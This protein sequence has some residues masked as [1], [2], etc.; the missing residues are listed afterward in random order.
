MAIKFTYK[1]T[2]QGFRIDGLEEE[3]RLHNS[4]YT[5]FGSKLQITDSN[6]SISIT[7]HFVTEEENE[8]WVVFC[9]PYF[10]KFFECL[11]LEEYE[12]DE[13]KFDPYLV[14]NKIIKP[15][16]FSIYENCECEKE[17]IP[18]KVGLQN[19]SGEHYIAFSWALW[20]NV[21]FIKRKKNYYSILLPQM[22]EKESFYTSFTEKKGRGLYKEEVIE[23]I[24]LRGCAFLDDQNLKNRTQNEEIE[25]EFEGGERLIDE[26]LLFGFPD[27]GKINRLFS[28]KK[29]GEDIIYRVDKSTRELSNLMKWPKTI[30][31]A[32]FLIYFSN[33][34]LWFVEEER[35]MYQLLNKIKKNDLL[36]I[37]E[38]IL[39]DANYPELLKLENNSIK[40]PRY[41]KK[42]SLTETPIELPDSKATSF[43][44]LKNSFYISTEIEKDADA[45]VV[46][47]VIED[48]L[49]SI[50]NIIQCNPLILEFNLDGD[51]FD[52]PQENIDNVQ[53]YIYRVCDIFK[54]EST[55]WIEPV[56]D[57]SFDIRVDTLQK[58]YKLND[59]SKNKLSR[60]QN[61]IWGSKE[62]FSGLNWL[63]FLSLDSLGGY[64][65]FDEI[66]KNPTEK[67]WQKKKQFINE[68]W[69]SQYWCEKWGGY[70][71]N[72]FHKWIKID[73]RDKSPELYRTAKQSS[74]LIVDEDIYIN[75][76]I[77]SVSF[78]FDLILSN[79][80]TYPYDI[81]LIRLLYNI[82]KNYKGQSIDK[83][84][85]PYI[86]SYPAGDNKVSVLID[87]VSLLEILCRNVL[88]PFS[89]VWVSLP[90]KDHSK[91]CENF[92][93]TVSG[94]GIDLIDSVRWG[95][96]MFGHL[97]YGNMRD[98]DE[99][100][101]E[102]VMESGWWNRW[103][104]GLF[105]KSYK[106]D[107]K[108]IPGGS[109]IK[110]GESKIG[111]GLIGKR[112][113]NF[114]QPYYMRF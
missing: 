44:K 108:F 91:T 113:I 100:N 112:L 76:I 9:K 45:Y 31:Q 7:G 111:K 34:N 80:N 72:F 75:D 81:K 102:I 62:D 61:M 82:L 63:P 88:I 103:Y 17:L 2:S 40:Y 70:K 67:I 15:G 60:V 22:P 58:A 46:E 73:K 37:P 101:W 65:A 84:H 29:I 93:E 27:R 48:K 87:Q 89:P 92:E 69:F 51:E 50:E 56:F 12:Y 18:L 98:F 30:E 107:L 90:Q 20:K 49:D 105:N 43:S 13:Y 28:E 5:I 33:T 41:F 52:S 94:R 86:E 19:L 14:S 109:G 85:I 77:K 106:N 95:G 11:L 10:Q 8:R 25:W 68:K 36:Y 59:F 78:L 32:S 54:G 26:F 53:K 39:R 47:V 38:S 96:R 55:L 97:L 74:G 4:L 42:I 114:I 23:E 24:L 6:E 1:K 83:L 66:G 64:F 21:A 16:V 99:N 3:N 110:I 71:E 57:N 104:R 79:K 35:H